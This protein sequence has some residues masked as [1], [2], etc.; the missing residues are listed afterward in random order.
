M[1]QNS[2]LNNNRLMPL[3]LWYCILWGA[4]GGST[5]TL[6]VIIV[7]ANLVSQGYVHTRIII[8]LVIILII[9]EDLSSSTSKPHSSSERYAP[10]FELTRKA[11]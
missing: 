5:R 11:H 2:W 8:I 3:W 4:T 10:C 9:T 1:K 7:G 6:Y